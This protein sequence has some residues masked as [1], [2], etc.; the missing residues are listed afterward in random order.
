MATATLS[1]PHKH[2]L[3]SA[4]SVE[5]FTEEDGYGPVDAPERDFRQNRY[6]NWTYNWQSRAGRLLLLAGRVARGDIDVSHAIRVAD[7][8]AYVTRIGDKFR[9]RDC[10]D[11]EVT[12]ADLPLRIA[13][14][15]SRGTVNPTEP[16]D[17]Y[18]LYGYAD[19][20]LEALRALPLPRWARIVV[21]RPRREPLLVFERGRT[22]EDFAYWLDKRRSPRAHVVRGRSK[23]LGALD[24]LLR[25]LTKRRRPAKS[26]TRVKKTRGAR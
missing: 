2:R 11:E 25:H 5:A 13:L 9:E 17:D 18:G 16:D 10:P 8:R 24:V 19:A 21:S 26:R 6:E 20:S 7:F 14:A 4:Y 22:I 12:D 15:M 23:P 3:G 1:G